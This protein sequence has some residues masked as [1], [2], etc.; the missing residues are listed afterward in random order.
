VVGKDLDVFVIGAVSLSHIYTHQLKIVNV[1]C[2][3]S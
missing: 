3:Q 2:S 1:I